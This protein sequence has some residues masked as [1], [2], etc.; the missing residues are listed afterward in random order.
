ME[1]TLVIAY[2]VTLGLPPTSKAIFSPAN[3][4]NPWE[5]SSGGAV[6][7]WLKNLENS[8]PNYYT[9]WQQEHPFMSALPFSGGFANFWGDKFL[10]NLGFT[11]GAIGSA[12][13]SDAAIA[14]VTNGIDELPLIGQQVGKAALWLNKIFSG[15]NKAEELMALGRSAGRTGDQLLQLQGLARASAARSVMDGTRYA[16]TLYGS[17]ASEAGFEA[18]DGYNTVRQDL[19]TA[20][21][22]EKGYSPTGVELETIDNYA[23]AAGNTRFGLNMALLGVSNA[24]QMETILK[25]FFSAKS[26]AKSADLAFVDGAF[27]RAVPESTIGKIWSRVKPTT[28]SVLREGVFEEG[29][30]FAA[31]IGTEYYYERRYLFDKGLSTKQYS[32]DETPWDAR[33]QMANIVHSVVSGLGAEFGTNEGLEN[34]LLGSLT[35]AIMGGGSAFLNRNREAQQTQATISMLNSQGVTGFIKDSYD[36]AAKSMR[37]SEDMKTAVANNDIFKYKNFQWEQFVEFVQSGIKAGRFDVRMEQ[38]DMLKEMNE[39]DFQ[40]A[41]GIDPT[42]DNIGSVG[43]YVDGLKRKAQQIKRSSE[44]ISKSFENPFSFTKKPSTAEQLEENM[45][46]DILDEEDGCIPESEQVTDVH[47]KKVYDKGHP[48]LHENF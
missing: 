48:I 16:V 44:L 41:W 9:K 6:D 14:A 42:V 1:P 4:G 45:F 11:V 17:T 33:D 47:Y 34:I 40:K 28:S 25:P 26:A 3:S 24:I 31:Q 8:F 37:I 12:V 21:Q 39:T 30:Q 29:G 7:N 27:Q 19:I 46:V 22:R 32:K 43:E 35:G 15:S 23:R 36:T 13:V 2:T 5:T 10:K 18:R 38:L 20:Y